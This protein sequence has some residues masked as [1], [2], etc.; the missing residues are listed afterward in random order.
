MVVA[1][2]GSSKIS[3]ENIIA[4]IG[5]IKIKELALFAPKMAVALK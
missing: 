3:I 5:T 4:L 2:I 1:I